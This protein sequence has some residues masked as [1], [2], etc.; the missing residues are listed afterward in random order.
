MYYTSDAVPSSFQWGLLTINVW[1]KSGGPDVSV[2]H[3]TI[4]APVAQT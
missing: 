1:Q 4:Q 3:T 2:F